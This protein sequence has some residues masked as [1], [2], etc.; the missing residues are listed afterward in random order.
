MTYGAPHQQSQQQSGGPDEGLRRRQYTTPSP[1]ESAYATNNGNGSTHWSRPSSTGGKREL[2]QKLD[3]MFPKV[4]PEFIVRTKGGG[5]ASVIA[6]VL[7]A[8]LC[9]AEVSTWLAQNRDIHS[10]ISVDTALGK[11]M[12]VT[13]N[14]TFPALACEDLHLDAIDVAG[15]SQLHVDGTT[16]QKIPLELDGSPI[17]KEKLELEAQ[18]ADKAEKDRQAVI[19]KEL[20]DNYCGPCYGAQE[21]EGQ[22]C[23]TCDDVLNAYAK[24]KWKADALVSSAEQCIKE[25][26]AS[27]EPK[28]MKKGEGCNVN[29]YLNLNRVSGNFHIAMGEGVERNGRHIHTYVPE[30]APNFNASHI[31]HSLAFGPS[32]GTDPLNGATKIVTDDTGSTGLFQYF[33]KVV[34]TTYIGESVIPD[35]FDQSDIVKETFQAADRHDDDHAMGPWVETNRFFFTERFRPLMVDDDNEDG[36]YHPEDGG[37]AHAVAGAAGGHSNPE[38]HQHQQSVL[39]GVFFIYEIYPFAVEY[40]PTEVPLMHLCIRLMATVGGV[41][42]LLKWVD[43]IIYDRKSSSSISLR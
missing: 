19:E 22:C 43:S 21:E 40:H 34:P 35:G 15:D 28:L 10:H 42:A 38:H 29:G 24:K 18:M 2:V 11:Q 39:P 41:I 23:Q 3:F 1:Y 16:L 25:G 4:D 13:M 20:P 7:I 32:D 17:P 14:I 33:I 26:R 36:R 31:I 12:T 27:K 6:Y 37:K 30:D 8:L 5:V 9:L